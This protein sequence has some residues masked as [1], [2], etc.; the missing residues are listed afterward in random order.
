MQRVKPLPDVIDLA[1]PG[2]KLITPRRHEDERGWFSEAWQ[3][4]DWHKIGIDTDF[5]QQNLAMNVRRGTLRG[6]HWQCEPYGQAKL[7]RCLTGSVL[8]VAADIRPGSPTF[9]R[10]VTVV[11]SAQAGSALYIPAGYGH[12]YLTLEDR[13]LVEYGVDAP[14]CPEAETACRWN[15]P[16]LAVDWGTDAPIL[17]AKDRAAPFLKG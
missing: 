2:V 17:S 14:W 6:I 11:L 3:R 9:G 8:D 10:S 16:T 1:L 7:I 15:D 4:D 5:M 13:T 12:G